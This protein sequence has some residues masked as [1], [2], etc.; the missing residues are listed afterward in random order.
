VART[1]A[2][3]L[4]VAFDDRQEVGTRSEVGDL[5]LGPQGGETIEG[6]ENTREPN[7]RIVAGH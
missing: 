5:M 2:D 6:L 3:D 4:E 1:L 7:A